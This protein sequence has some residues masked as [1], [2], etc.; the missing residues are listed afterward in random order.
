MQSYFSLLPL[1]HLASK[2]ELFWLSGILKRFLK[3]FPH[4]IRWKIYFTVLWPL[5]TP[6]EHELNKIDSALYPEALVYIWALM[7]LWFIRKKILKWPY[8]IFSTF[9]IYPPLKRIWTFIWMNLNSHH[10]R[11]VSAKFDWIGQMFHFK[12][13]FQYTNEKIEL[14][15]PPPWPSGTIICSSLNLHH[16]IKLSCKYQ[17]FWVSGS[18]GKKNSMTLPNF[19]IFMIISLWRGPGPLFEQF[20][21]PFTQGWFVPSLTEIGMLVLEEKIFFSI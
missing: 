17:L 6:K 7:V 4:W 3:I 1:D 10:A 21:I 16:V 9:V 13:S 20:R 2:Y 19:R 14:L 5:I 12:D 8:P 11:N 18:Q 15:C